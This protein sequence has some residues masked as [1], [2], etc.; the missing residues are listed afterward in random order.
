MFQYDEIPIQVDVPVRQEIIDG[1]EVTIA[2]ADAG[3][4][5]PAAAR[6]KL[7]VPLA[8]GAVGVLPDCLRAGPGAN[9]GESNRGARRRLL[10]PPAERSS[11]VAEHRRRGSGL[12]CDS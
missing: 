3:G 5:E 7:A 10:R 1:R 6:G 4:D 2:G 9:A 11:P 8:L 12:L